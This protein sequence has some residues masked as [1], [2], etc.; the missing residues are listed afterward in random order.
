[1]KEGTQSVFG[2]FYFDSFA[3]FASLRLRIF[4]KFVNSQLVR[5]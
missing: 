3:L 5:D 4:S 2:I 1:M